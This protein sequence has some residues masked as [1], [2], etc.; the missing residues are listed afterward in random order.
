MPSFKT[1]SCTRKC[2]FLTADDA[3]AEA[4][5][6]NRTATPRVAV[7]YC[8]LCRYFHV[9]HPTKLSK[10]FKQTLLRRHG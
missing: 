8:K 7:Y 1:Q 10:R 6:I 5:K 4:N 3:Q 9:G 2:Q